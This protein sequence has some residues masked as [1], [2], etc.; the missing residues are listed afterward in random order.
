MRRF[1]VI[2]LCVSSFLI[3]LP[4][5]AHAWWYWMD[6]YTGPGPFTGFDVQWRLA[7]LADPAVPA[8]ALQIVDTKRKEALRKAL[9]A[10]TPTPSGTQTPA[11]GGTEQNNLT[12][13]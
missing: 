2:G 1:I 12:A 13:G 4:A 8:L 10:F 9:P 5:H 7:C 11:F 3:T 6:E